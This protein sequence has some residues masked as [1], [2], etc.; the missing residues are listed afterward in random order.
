MRTLAAVSADLERELAA[1]DWTLAMRSLARLRAPVDAFFERVLVNDPD[2]AVRL[3]RLRLLSHHPGCGEPRGGLLVDP[4]L[5]R[6]SAR[7]AAHSDR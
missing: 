3:N 7:R 4:G 1:E 5:S 6:P 2:P